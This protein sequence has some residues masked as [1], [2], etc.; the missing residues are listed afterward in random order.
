[1]PLNKDVGNWIKDFMKSNA[2]QFKG[3]SKEERKDMALAAYREK[4]GSLEEAIDVADDY[5]NKLND[6]ALA[7]FRAQMAA[8]EKKAAEPKKSI[9][10]NYAA[11]KNADKIDALKKKRAQ[12]MI[13]MEQE[14]EPEGG[15]IADRYG[16][17]LNKIDAAIDKLEGRKEMTYDQAIYMSK[18]EIERRAA[19]LEEE[20]E[21]ATAAEEDKFHRDL[22]KLV[23]KTFG[24]SSDEKKEM[25]E[26]AD[27]G[28]DYMK[29]ID[30]VKSADNPQNLSVYY[31]SDHDKVN[32]G[33][34]GYD[35]GD[36]VKMFNLQ[37]GQSS[38]VKAL[39]YK[40]N[41]Y[42][43]DVVNAI[44]NEKAGVKA[45]LK[46]GYGEEPFV[47]YK[48]VNS[49]DENKEME[50]IKVGTF[51][52]YK[53]DKNFTGGKVKSID[54][55][56][57]EIHNWDGSTTT[58]PLKDLEYVESWNEAA[59]PDF[60]DIDEDGNTEEPMKKAAKDA[61]KE[62]VE[63]AMKKIK[64]VGATTYAGKASE[65]DVKKDPNWGTLTGDAK[66][67]VIDKLKKGGTVSLG[68]VLT[69]GHKYDYEGKMAQSQLLSIVKNARDL[70]NMMDEK[71]QLKSWVQSKL[72]KA[73]DYLD[74]VRTY[75][76]GE[77]LS[78]TVPA[79]F[80]NDR[81][82]DETGTAL[83]IGDVVK[84]GDGRIYQIVFSASE[85]KP[86]LVPFDLKRRKITTLRNKVYFDD[87]ESSVPKKLNKVDFSATKGGFMN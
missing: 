27:M 78:S 67:D 8:R 14:A 20:E 45:Q 58:L 41:Q 52:R 25:K 9:N 40:A 47:T 33:G 55:D 16:D 59:K 36:L 5:T 51:V 62:A 18:D 84:G 81:V 10:P 6:P 2:P 43:E 65:D 24:H 54:G 64:E 85:G 26:E 80:K 32:I 19:S 56:N 1:M 68:E 49:L 82:S 17:M 77:A 42:A 70:F 63:K 66:V 61:K 60:L 87:Q 11:V 3:K 12:I 83:S 74:A 38:D 28:V 71:T 30:L 44:N 34:V 86:S 29:I 76:E 79:M 22:D 15:P 57:V 7:A 50:E 21:G 39:F 13:D 73:E 31:N 35:K 75:L 48:M 53:K 46:Y 37:P 23:H 69:E 4:Y 72:T